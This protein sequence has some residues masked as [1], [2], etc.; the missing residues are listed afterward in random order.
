MRAASLF[1]LIGTFALGALADGA[2]CLT[3]SAASRVANNFAALIRSYTPELAE[4]ALC[5]DFTDYSDSVAELINSGCPNGPQALGAA[6]FTSLA[7]F[8]AGQGSQPAIPF[9]ILN[10]WHNCD[11]VTMRWRT[12]APGTVVP[13]EPVTGIVVMETIY[14]GSGNDEPWLIETVYSEFNSGAWLYDLGI[15][16]PTACNATAAKHR[17]N[18]NFR[19]ARRLL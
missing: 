2:P 18:L 8:M 7:S 5:T 1:T 17:R 4:Q 10:T 16:V 15:F 14:A 3:D 9:E 19:P 13:E 11:T 6:T 12:S